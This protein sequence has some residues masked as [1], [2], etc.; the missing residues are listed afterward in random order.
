MTKRF[1]LLSM[2]AL[3]LLIATTIFIHY[4]NDHVECETEVKTSIGESGEK[5]TVTKHV[6]RERFSF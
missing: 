2:A 4:S 1:I 5:I 3:T 6:C